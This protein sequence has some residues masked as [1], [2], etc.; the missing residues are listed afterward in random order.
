MTRARQVLALF[1]CSWGL[2]GCPDG[3]ADPP[4]PLNKPEIPQAPPRALGALA[5]GTDAAPQPDR[6][7]G[8]EVT[9]SLP[10]PAV[11]TPPLPGSA[12]SGPGGAV[13][14]GAPDAGMAL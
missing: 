7:P 12:G 11:P 13:E 14:P 8:V 4:P 2:L 3:S 5:A 6:T 10:L 1:V 9:P